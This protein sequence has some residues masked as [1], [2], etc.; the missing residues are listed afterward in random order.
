ML[1]RVIRRLFRFSIEGL[2]LLAFGSSL[3]GPS[4][5]GATAR[6]PAAGTIAERVD[7]VRQ[8]LRVARQESADTPMIR[9]SQYWPNWPNWPNGW[10]NWGNWWRNF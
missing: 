2:S 10:G 7:A 8:Q 9:V 4:S 5:A 6:I 1:P 3:F